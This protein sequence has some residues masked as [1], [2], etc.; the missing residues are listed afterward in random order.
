MANTDEPKVAEEPSFSFKEWEKW[1][2]SDRERQ[3][4]LVRRE[5]ERLAAEFA[6]LPPLPPRVP[7]D[8]SSRE[9]LN[10]EIR[11][12]YHD[13][14]RGDLEAVRRYVEQHQPS[15]GYLQ[16]GVNEAASHGH[17]EVVR[18]L[19]HAGAEFTSHVLYHACMNPSLRLFKCLVEEKSWH[20]N[21]AMHASGAVALPY[22][23]ADEELL[24]Y[25]LDLG[26]D[27][28]LGTHR[29]GF[30]PGVPT[31]RRSGDALEN[32]AAH[33]EPHIIDLLIS[34]GARLEFAPAVM[35][36]AVLAHSPNKNDRRAMVLHLLENHCVSINGGDSRTQPGYGDTPMMAA[37]NNGKVAAAEMLLE[38]GASPN[39]TPVQPAWFKELVEKVKA[40]KGEAAFRADILAARKKG[41]PRGKYPMPYDVRIHGKLDEGGG[42]S[43]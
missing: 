16:Y 35:H 8:N 23:I 37:I 27:P 2:K 30:N 33:S 39:S 31:D 38:V 25:L 43:A 1:E 3:R 28:N 6:G 11:G 42:S 34:Y 21:Q 22:C 29:T 17:V 9:T 18:Y 36:R 10:D 24:R 32:A 7:P 19:F 26:A 12:F 13:C 40:R 20:P 5:N 15:V 14:A 41:T 4:N